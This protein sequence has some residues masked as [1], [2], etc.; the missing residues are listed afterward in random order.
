MDSQLIPKVSSNTYIAIIAPDSNR[1][2]AD[3]SSPSSQ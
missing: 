3:G 1:F 2:L